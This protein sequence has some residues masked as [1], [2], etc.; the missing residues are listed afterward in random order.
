MSTNGGHRLCLQ[1]GTPGLG[2]GY[3]DG[4]DTDSE[5]KA[6]RRENQELRALL[7]ELREDVEGLEARFLDHVHKRDD[8]ESHTSPTVIIEAP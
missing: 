4:M 5:I 6:L 8:E 3:G 1:L 2:G 7:D